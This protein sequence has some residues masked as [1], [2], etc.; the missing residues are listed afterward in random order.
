MFH[1]PPNLRS[2]L[3]SAAACCGVLGFG[4]ASALPVASIHAPSSSM[5]TLLEP[6]TASPREAEA[7]TLHSDSGSTALS[8]LARGHWSSA[9][10]IATSVLAQ[11]LADPDALGIFALC[12][13]IRNDTDAVNTAT[14]RLREAEPVSHYGALVQGVMSLNTD[15][16]EQAETSFRTVLRSQAS[17]SLALYFLGEALHAQRKDAPALT[18]F[19]AVL[20]NWP[21]HIPALTVMARLM[22]GPKATPK[23]LK[24]ALVMAERATKLNPVNLA[25]WRLLAG[26]CERTGQSGRANAIALQWLSGPP[27]IKPMRSN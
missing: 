14:R 1:F 22:A 23:E 8:A 24:E 15:A 3:M 9:C 2:L 11:K 20:K 12:A 4:A 21:E 27:Q 13:A 19:K 26:L 25:H 16:P 7:R 10:R 18:A 5:A 6:E 17:D